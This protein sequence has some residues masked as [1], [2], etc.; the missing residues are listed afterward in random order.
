MRTSSSTS[1]SS[2]RTQAPTGIL[3]VETAHPTY[4][5]SSYGRNAYVSAI[6]VKKRKLLWRS[7]ALVA[8]AAHFVLLNDTIVSGY[9]FTAEPDYLYALD[10]ATGKVKGRLLS[11]A[12]RRPSPA[13]ATCSR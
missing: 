12:R 3:Y 4:A 10:R 5:K 2:G 1:R 6:D 7:P 11:R 9:G 13:T 8:N